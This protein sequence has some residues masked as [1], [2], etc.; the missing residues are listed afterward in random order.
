MH[1]PCSGYP[2]YMSLAQLVEGEESVKYFQ[3]GIELM[4]TKK[5]KIIKGEEEEEEEVEGAAA[6]PSSSPMAKLEELQ[7]DISRGREGRIGSVLN[8]HAS[9][10]SHHSLYF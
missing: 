9:T 10:N 1:S 5:D 6:I 3:K 2:K 4:E 8:A 7:S